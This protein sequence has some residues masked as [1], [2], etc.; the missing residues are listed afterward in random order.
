MP[1]DESPGMRR[2]IT[3]VVKDRPLRRRRRTVL[4]IFSMLNPAS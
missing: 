3:L 4:Y 2:G 1:P